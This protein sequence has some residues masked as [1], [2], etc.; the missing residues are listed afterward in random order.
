[1]ALQNEYVLEN[2]ASIIG[3]FANERR[4][5]KARRKSWFES[6]SKLFEIGFLPF[7]CVPRRA[8]RKVTD[9]LYSD[10][11]AKAFHI[12]GV[13]SG[14]RGA[15]KF[16]CFDFFGVRMLHESY[17]VTDWE[18]FSEF[19]GTKLELMFRAAKCK[20]VLFE[21]DVSF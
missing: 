10:P 5:T 18:R 17:F 12:T 8:R 2:K 3:E 16:T 20:E 9:P 15:T 6:R 4:L 7:N 1:M 19:L 14:H 13:N 21:C 11:P